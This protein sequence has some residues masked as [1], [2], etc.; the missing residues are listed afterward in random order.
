MERG[1]SAKNT[2]KFRGKM[3]MGVVVGL[4][5]PAHAI[6]FTTTTRRSTDMAAS[7]GM[8]R[9]IRYIYVVFQ[10][11]VLWDRVRWF[12]SPGYRHCW[13]FHSVWFPEKS[14]MADEYTLK[15]EV[16]SSRIDTA[17]WWADPATVADS[18]VALPD[19]TTILR[20]RVD[21]DD[22]I[23]YIPRGM[24]TC[25][26]GVKALLGVRAWWV[27]T[28]KQLHN[29]LLGIGAEPHEGPNDGRD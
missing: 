21:I 16:T 4:V 1:G 28:P 10:E 26:S 19:V 22:Q 29:Y 14:L 8:R 7:F 5:R 18:F 17:I 20:V 11:S 13:A 27:V 23:R 3:V 12:T 9:E 25:V 24:L 15:M 6:R 2:P